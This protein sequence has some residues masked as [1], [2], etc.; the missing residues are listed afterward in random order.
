MPGQ[1]GADG[2]DGKDGHTP[3]IGVRKDTDGIYYWTLDGKWLTDS[4]GNKIPTTGKDGADGKPG[5]DG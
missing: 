4:K 2:A 1:D 5:V 3:Q